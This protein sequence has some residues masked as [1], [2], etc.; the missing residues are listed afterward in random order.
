M[1]AGVVVDTGGTLSH[2]AIVAREYNIPAVLAT[3][4]A[5]SKLKD[6]DRVMVDGT[7]GK[8]VKLG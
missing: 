5:T 2:A 8:V 6:G 1:A 4:D 3:G 7:S